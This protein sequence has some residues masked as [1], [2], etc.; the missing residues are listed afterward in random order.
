MVFLE[1]ADD[2]FVVIGSL[3]EID[4]SCIT[5]DYLE[6]DRTL[7]DRLHAIG[8]VLLKRDCDC[9]VSLERIPCAVVSDSSNSGNS[10]FGLPI[11]RCVLR[12]R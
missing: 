2:E 1:L 4:A 7:E 12:K 11:R 10:F 3:A 5:F 6:M 9:V 8:T